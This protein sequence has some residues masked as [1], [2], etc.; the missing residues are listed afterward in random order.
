MYENRKYKR[1]N[2]ISGTKFLEYTPDRVGPSG[3]KIV[4][5]KFL[6]RCG[7]EYITTV[8]RVVG[9]SG[10]SCGCLRNQD[11]R[12]KLNEGD[13][14]NGFKYIG[15][16]VKCGTK[17]KGNFECPLCNKVFLSTI[18]EI[19][20]G[21]NKSCGCLISKVT[22]ERNTIHGKSNSLAYASYYRMIARCYDKNN[23][24]YQYY[25]GKGIKVCDRWLESFEN[26]YADMGDRPSFE[27]SIERLNT[28]SDYS[29]DNCK[30]ATR[31]EQ[32]RNK[33]NNVFVVFNGESIRL[34][35]LLQ[36]RDILNKRK[37][38]Y[39]RIRQG[40][41]INKAIIV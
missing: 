32:A 20:R 18:S 10:I 6:C 17:L 41:D 37:L 15:G 21:R 16:V 1:G 3:R 38:V 27:H 5:G 22:I 35:K 23:N 30:W 4:M 14:I 31:L 34:V 13:I 26:F 24:R 8:G 39:N 33:S 29:P 7:K 11:K 19:N 36:D 25:G 12:I 2:Y 40:W 9:G 28:E